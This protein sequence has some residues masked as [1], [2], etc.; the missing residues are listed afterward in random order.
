M[1]G[2][3]KAVEA[4]LLPRPLLVNPPQELSVKNRQPRSWNC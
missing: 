1:T 3:K 2:E 4:A